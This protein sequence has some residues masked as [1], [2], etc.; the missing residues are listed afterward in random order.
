MGRSG[1][2]SGKS[3]VKAAAVTAL[4]APTAR[5]A[6]GKINKAPVMRCSNRASS[7]SPVKVTVV[8]AEGATTARGAFGK[9]PL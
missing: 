4:E 7:K 5:G 6:F 2:A 9:R 1:H 8:T 3:A